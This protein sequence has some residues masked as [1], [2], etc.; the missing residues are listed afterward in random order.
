MEPRAA[1]ALALARCIRA[2]RPDV[3]LAPTTTPDQHPDHAVVGSLAQAAARLARY[4][5]VPELRDVPHH[6]VGRALAYAVTPGG[7]PSGTARRLALRVDVSRHL[8]AWRALM[9]C[10]A[11]QMRT[12]RY[13]DLQLA[14]AHALGLES[15]VEH[16]QLLFPFDPLLVRSLNE[17]P[18]AAR[19]F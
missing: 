4:G 14:R 18:P 11:T 8:E 17:L 16:A 2:F 3:L 10:H 6:A 15:G 12:R 5:G 13:L 7:E 1:H 19:L 9:E